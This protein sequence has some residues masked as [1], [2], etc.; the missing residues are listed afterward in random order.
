MNKDFYSLD[1]ALRF[2]EHSY[3]HW[4]YFAAERYGIQISLAKHY[5]W[6]AFAV[7][8]ALAFIFNAFLQYKPIQLNFATGFFFVSGFFALASFMLG[9]I[10]LSSFWLGQLKDPAIE[11]HNSTEFISKLTAQDERD[12]YENAQFIIDRCNENDYAIVAYHKFT[13]ERGKRLRYQNI[14]SLVAVTCCTISFLCFIF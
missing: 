7:L 2:Y 1:D 10:N 13:H 3:Q 6:I 14:L 8:T 5:Q 11:L 12:S 9:T 4:H